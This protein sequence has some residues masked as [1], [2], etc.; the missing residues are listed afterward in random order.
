LNVFVNLFIQQAIRM[1]HIVI[2]GLPWSSFSHKLRDFG[3]ILT[4]MKC[5]FWG[6]I[7]NFVWNIVYSKQNLGMYDLKCTF[8]FTWSTT[9]S[10]HIL[11]NL[12]FL[13]IFLKNI[14]I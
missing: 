5:V 3:K 9:Y 7:Y 6:S 11:T 12:N 10:C 4:N 8:V 14:E 1:H 2:R 13:D